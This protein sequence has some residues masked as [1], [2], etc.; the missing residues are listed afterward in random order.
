MKWQHRATCQPAWTSTG[1]VGFLKGGTPGTVEDTGV[2]LSEIDEC[3]GS[4]VAL[5]VEQLTDVSRPTDG[6]RA[7]RKT[8]DLEH[9]AKACP[10][11]KTIKLADLIDNS[12]SIVARDPTFAVIYLKEKAALLEVLYEGD[13]TLFEM[14]RAIVDAGLP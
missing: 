6:N 10:E 9:T 1:V 7:K 3:F 13:P 8:L 4:H 12:K 5:L 2:T 11:A 14:A